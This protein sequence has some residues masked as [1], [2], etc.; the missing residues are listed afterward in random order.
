V[1]TVSSSERDPPLDAVDSPG[2]A[3]G[4]RLVTIA[5]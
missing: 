2:A 3:C 1:W 5:G 4:Q